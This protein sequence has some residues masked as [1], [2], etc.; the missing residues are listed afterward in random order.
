MEIFFNDS[1]AIIIG[2]YIGNFDPEF[3]ENS[4]YV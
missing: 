1:F 4:F 2:K 3:A